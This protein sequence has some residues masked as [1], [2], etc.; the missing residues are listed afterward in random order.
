M[1]TGQLVVPLGAD[2]RSV[3]ENLVNI[4]QKHQLGQVHEEPTCEDSQLDLVFTSNPSLIKS[5]TNIPGLSDHNAITTDCGIKPY[6]TNKK[7]KKLFRFGKADWDSLR[8]AASAVSEKVVMQGK[9]NGDVEGMWI[10]FKTDLMTAADNFIPSAMGSR[11]HRLLWIDFKLKKCWTRRKDYTAKPET[12]NL[13]GQSTDSSK[14]N[15]R[16]SSGKLSKTMSETSSKV[17]RRR[18]WNHFGNMSSQKDK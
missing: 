6:C 10:A 2:N 17:Y 1:W 14:K 13:T 8:M 5:S 4:S 15:A 3:K 12:R 9:A 18:I 16:E 7:L 11:K